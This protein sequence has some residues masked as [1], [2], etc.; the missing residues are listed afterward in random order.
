MNFDAVS[1]LYSTSANNQNVGY[2]FGSTTSMATTTIM[3]NNLN[4]Y[5]TQNSNNFTATL[6]RNLT[7]QKICSK[8]SKQNA[9]DL[10]TGSN[11]YASTTSM[12]QENGVMHRKNGSIRSSSYS[13]N[14]NWRNL[15]I[16][17]SRSST[18]F[19]KKSNR[20]N[21]LRFFQRKF[22][23]VSKIWKF[24]NSSVFKGL[25]N[26][27]YLFAY[28]IYMILLKPFKNIYSNMWETINVAQSHLRSG[29]NNIQ[30][31][32]TNLHQQQ[33]DLFSTS[34]DGSHLA[35]EDSE[36]DEE[37]HHERNN[38]NFDLHRKSQIV[39]F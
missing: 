34:G 30:H 36:L 18:F 7:S 17:S 35:D 16:L 39:K 22:L 13:T 33:D 28:V 4:V 20:S 21:F 14:N 31:L 1:T 25:F 26:V 9:G 5:S 3:A 27:F 32:P 29:A 6:R 11:N 37:F 2:G 19:S 23:V 15:D 8:L 24:F 10:L 12:G 38:L